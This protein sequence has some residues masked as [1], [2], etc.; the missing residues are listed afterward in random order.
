MDSSKVSAVRT[1]K[2]D[3]NSIVEY[4]SEGRFHGVWYQF[5]QKN[6]LKKMYTFNHGK[7]DGLQVKFD[8]HERV[9]YIAQAKDLSLMDI[10]DLEFR[11]ASLA[12]QTMEYACIAHSER[13][14]LLQR[15]NAN[16]VAARKKHEG[17]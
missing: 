9:Q 3:E 15:E 16:L 17:R 8:E 4:D 6:R 2:R 7:F 10:D 12:E 13:N 5:D 14:A 1:F 11:K